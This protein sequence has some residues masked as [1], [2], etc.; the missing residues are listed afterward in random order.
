MFSG[1]RSSNQNSNN[2]IN[3]NNN[4]N[5]NNNKKRPRDR[6]NQQQYQMNSFQ[7]SQVYNNNFSN[8]Q[9]SSPE[10][11]RQIQKQRSFETPVKRSQFAQPFHHAAY[12]TPNQMQNLPSTSQ[13]A[14]LHQNC[15]T[16]SSTQNLQ[17]QNLQQPVRKQ[18]NNKFRAPV[19]TIYD[20]K[21]KE[22]DERF[23]KAM[24]LLSECNKAGIEVSI[25]MRQLQSPRVNL[26]KIRNLIHE[27]MMK[28]LTPIGAVKDFVFGSTLTGLD[29]HGSD[30][31]Y[32]VELKNPPKSEADVKKT[33]S[34]AAKQTHY[35]QGQEFQV[36]A[37][38]PN[39]R[40]PLLRLLHKKTKVICDVNFT[41]IFGYYNSYFIGHVLDYD[42]RIK[43]LAVLLKLWS[44]SCKLSS[45]M[46][47]SNYC[48]IMCMI[49]YLQNL[50]EPMLNSISNNQHARSKMILDENYKW[51]FYFNDNINWS[52]RNN[53]SL[54]ELF[55]G[56]F[57]FML[58]IDYTQ[59]IVS[60]FTGTLIKRS[61]FNQHPDL[62]PYRQI[63]NENDLP[64]L[65]IDCPSLFIIQDGFELNLNIGIKNKKH[66]DIFLDIVKMSHQKCV[67]LKDSPFSELLIHLFS[68][69]IQDLSNQ[70]PLKNKKKFSMTIH[71]I[72]GDLKVSNST[73]T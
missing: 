20:S 30:L 2:N 37:I 55:V 5:M 8:N 6:V 58:N 46:I 60:I 73:C 12:Q 63:I 66:I 23:G 29:F 42:K 27:D 10:P 71:A 13:Q 9:V 34:L 59:N 45:R 14:N 62:E 38:I 50:Q 53:Q 1:F 22:W 69:P 56:F 47:M 25:L 26:T 18:K 32:Y 72:A 24:K 19:H 39:A 31:D 36:I 48:L 41:S 57:D 49:F 51:N 11:K 4:Y 40:V 33:L 68:L 28:M 70:K 65:K 67:E 21:A 16:T 44:K 61:E 17:Q 54:R 43:D 64:P 52:T 15:T 7:Q 35:L 3:N